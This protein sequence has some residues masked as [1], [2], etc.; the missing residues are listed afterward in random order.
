MD[1]TLPSVGFCE[2]VETQPANPIDIYQ[3]EVCCEQFMSESVAVEHVKTHEMAPSLAATENANRYPCF[4]C[5]E[6]FLTVSSL[7]EHPCVNTAEKPLSVAEDCPP[8]KKFRCKQC[9]KR[10]GVKE[11]YQRHVK[12]HGRKRPNRRKPVVI[13]EEIYEKVDARFSLSTRDEQF[14]RNEKSD[15]ELSDNE[16]SDE[17]F[18]VDEMFP[19]LDVEN[20]RNALEPLVIAEVKYECYV[21]LKILSTTQE[22]MEHMRNHDPLL[23]STEPVN[24]HACEVCGK[25]FPKVEDLQR[26]MDV[27]AEWK[28]IECNICHDTFKQISHLKNHILVVHNP[29]GLPRKKKPLSHFCEICNKGF[30][31]PCMLKR[32]VRSHTGEKPFKCSLCDEQFTRKAQIASHMSFMHNDGKSKKY[33]CSAKDCGKKFA[34]EASLNNHMSQHT[35]RR[36]FSCEECGRI[37]FSRIGLKNH[38][39]LHGGDIV[40]FKC[41]V[42]DEIFNSHSSLAIHRRVHYDEFAYECQV[43][44][45]KFE[46]KNAFWHHSVKKCG[47]DAFEYLCDY[48]G[49][50][51]YFFYE[52]LLIDHMKGHESLRG[53]CST[54]AAS[55]TPHV[56][57]EIRAAEACGAAPIDE[58]TNRSTQSQMETTTVGAV[59]SEIDLPEYK[60]WFDANEDTEDMVCEIGSPGTGTWPS[61]MGTSLIGNKT[62]PSELGNPIL[63][64]GTVP[65]IIRTAENAN[66]PL[67]M[68]TEPTEIVTRTVKNEWGAPDV[69]ISSVRMGTPSAAIWTPSATIQTPSVAIQTPSAAV[70]TTSAP[71]RSPSATVQSTSAA[72]QNPTA[73][74]QTT[75]A[76][77]GTPST[78][79]QNPIAQVCASPAEIVSVPSEGRDSGPDSS[80]WELKCETCEEK[81]TTP[82]LLD[83]HERSHAYKHSCE[84]CG[85]RFKFLLDVQRHQDVHTGEKK[86]ACHICSKRYKSQSALKTHVR[87]VH[88]GGPKRVQVKKHFCSICTKGFYRPG[89]LA[90]HVLLHSGV[91]RYQCETCKMKFVWKKALRMHVLRAHSGPRK[92]HR[93]TFTNCKQS[94]LTAH[95]LKRHLEKH[96][97]RE[98]IPCEVCG[99]VFFT[100]MKLRLHMVIHGAIPRFQCDICNRACSSKDRL[101]EHR[102]TH[103][104]EFAGECQVCREMFKNGVGLLRHSRRKCGKA[105]YKYPCHSDDCLKGFL[106]EEART[107]H[108]GA[109]NLYGQPGKG[110]EAL[111]TE[112]RTPS[113]ATGTR[114]AKTVSLSPAEGIISTAQIETP[115]AVFNSSAEVKRLSTPHFGTGRDNPSGEFQCQTC[116]NVFTNSSRLAAHELTHSAGTL[117]RDPLSI[118]G[119]RP[120]LNTAEKS[121]PATSFACRKCSDMFSSQSDL[122]QH[123]V[124]NHTMAYVCNDCG[125]RFKT[126]TLLYKHRRKISKETKMLDSSILIPV[127]LTTV[128]VQETKNIYEC[129]IC[130]KQL[131]SHHSI[132][133]HIQSMHEPKR[134]API[135]TYQYNCQVCNKSFSTV[136]NLNRHM[137]THSGDKPF[138]CEHCEKRFTQATHYKRHVVTTHGTGGSQHFICMHPGC[139]RKYAYDHD[140]KS[141][142]SQVHGNQK[143]PCPVCGKRFN[144]EYNVRRHQSVHELARGDKQEVQLNFKCEGCAWRFKTEKALK[145]HMMS[146][147][148]FGDPTYNC[149]ACDLPYFTASGLERHLRAVH[150]GQTPSVSGDPVSPCSTLDGRPHL[151]KG[152]GKRFRYIHQLKRHE[153]KHM[154][155]A[156]KDDMPREPVTCRKCGRSFHTKKLLMR[157]MMSNHTMGYLCRICG[158]RFHKRPM[159]VQHMRNVHSETEDIDD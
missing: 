119:T 39:V 105:A 67:L 22:L 122:M 87:A 88:D 74:I 50:E 118:I 53:D 40:R 66:I 104:G 31:A 139:G 149:D 43:C 114:S 72:V 4:V 131:S 107:R 153:K 137:V 146:H 68:A 138:A 18:S 125:Q 86:Y 32:H 121:R 83:R 91:K 9:G 130:F 157:H 20:Q 97:P 23:A 8:P 56:K 89:L 42:C 155:T 19:R 102:N 115:A 26:H 90:Q 111:P 70:G 3:C 45:K 69:Q 92:I 147:K 110:I 30:T 65:D 132:R 24:K 6:L 144:T 61:K 145:R 140:L 133:R 120:T 134:K 77:I 55:M 156:V 44:R 25:R 141:H 35:E 154:A 38:M 108:M 71:V 117:T 103:T 106:T 33:K 36:K 11:N 109:H 17:E 81:F 76:A 60:S 123:I 12:L 151:C 28:R 98:N 21:C 58:E 101:L 136:S 13:A 113:A 116:L 124:D 78:A 79:I 73:A 80:G 96:S 15:E 1:E 54:D 143:F 5:G 95:S 34:T 85:R 64:L 47:K 99:E 152:C 148:K 112:A 82:V 150:D 48:P 135:V 37:F 126:S 63:D 10:F 93:C 14:R 94:F 129:G 51:Q 127:S 41:G 62:G 2:V 16:Q 27:H 7:K 142:M 59:P 49:C 52:D 159:F 84:Q 128:D 100:R 46:T 75:S 57:M 29:D 158:D